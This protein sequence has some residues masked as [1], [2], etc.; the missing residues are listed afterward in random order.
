M[1]RR[2]SL[3]TL[4]VAFAFFFLLNGCGMKPGPQLVWSFKTKRPM[5]LAGDSEA[6]TPVSA[7][8]SLLFCGGYFWND[9]SKLYR[10]R[11]SDGHAL[12][13]YAVG[14]CVAPPLISG[15]TVIAF[16]RDH[17][18][19]YLHAL[20]LETG[21]RKWMKSF[22]VGAFYA[23]EP[24]IA[25]ESLYFLTPDGTFSR[26]E[27][28]S[29]AL[30]PVAEQLCKGADPLTRWITA[31][32]GNL[33]AGCGTQIISISPETEAEKP[34]ASL[35]HLP[36]HI[37]HA[38]SGQ[39]MLLL[40]EGESSL[41]AFD[42]T[43]GKRMWSRSFQRIYSPPLINRGQIYVTIFSGGIRVAAL[44]AVTGA[45]QT[46]L[47]TG[48]FNPPAV[49]DGQIYAT[50]PSEMISADPVSGKTLRKWPSPSEIVTSPVVVGKTLVWGTIKG[51]LLAVPLD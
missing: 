24:V 39:K 31:F 45:T 33:L 7:G 17:E 46:L 8:D 27:F 50:G 25:G 41:L 2:R 42:L 30:H 37:A 15:E 6:L 29:G 48:W 47:E 10:L 22:P 23:P 4:S 49:I 19:F 5:V 35:D 1:L 51:E 36:G 12:W 13:E 3:S 14:D 11:A 40:T 28:A 26:F 34:L 21:R 38:S 43:T 20:D 9:W 18:Q 44:N 16:S 32:E